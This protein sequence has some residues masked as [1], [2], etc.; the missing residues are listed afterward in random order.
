[1]KSKKTLLCGVFKFT[2]EALLYML[3]AKGH[4][5]WRRAGF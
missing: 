5:L 1:M 4:D 2:N 3:L